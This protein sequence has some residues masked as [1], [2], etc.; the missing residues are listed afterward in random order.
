SRPS[1]SPPV[2]RSCCTTTRGS[3]A[4][5]RSRGPTRWPQPHARRSGSEQAHNLG[6]V[7]SEVLLRRGSA[8]GV[9]S[10]PYDDPREATRVVLG[11]LPDLPHLPELP[12]RGP[13]ADMIGRAAAILAELAVDL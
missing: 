2:S 6:F 4:R 1:V 9:G 5:P 12:G 13:G 3:S 11:E 8:T 10:L 7:P